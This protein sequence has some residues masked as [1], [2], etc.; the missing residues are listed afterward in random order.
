M[1]V[2]PGLLRAYELEAAL[3]FRGN[4]GK[5]KEVLNELFHSVGS[6]KAYLL[7]FFQ[8]QM[9][10]KSLQVQAKVLSMSCMSCISEI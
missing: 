5:S 4:E 8:G 3:G 9:N 7:I 1:T 2:F 10:L 6:N